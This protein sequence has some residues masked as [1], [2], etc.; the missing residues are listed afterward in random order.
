MCSQGFAPQWVVLPNGLDF[1]DVTLH[2]ATL[3][4][5]S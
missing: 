2:R 1:Y 5:S 4:R 3:R